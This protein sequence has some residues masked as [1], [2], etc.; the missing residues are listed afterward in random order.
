[1]SSGLVRLCKTTKMDEHSRKEP[2]RDYLR[3]GLHLYETS[4]SQ[5]IAKCLEYRRV[6]NAHVEVTVVERTSPVSICPASDGS[7]WAQT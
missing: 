1:M 3:V 5:C 2:G 6:T 7:Y 4:M